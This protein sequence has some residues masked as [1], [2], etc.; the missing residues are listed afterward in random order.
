MH[1]LMFTQEGS[2]GE[3]SGG[4]GKG[5]AWRGWEEEGCLQVQNNSRD[6]LVHQPCQISRDAL[7]HQPC[8]ISRTVVIYFTCNHE[9]LSPSFSCLYVR[10][11][12]IVV[13]DSVFICSGGDKDFVGRVKVFH[14]NLTD[15]RVYADIVWLYRPKE[16]R[17]KVNRK[18]THLVSESAEN[19]VFFSDD[20]GTIEVPT[21][22]RKAHIVTT[23]HNKLPPKILGD[24]SL[25]AKFSF[26]SKTKRLSPLLSERLGSPSGKV[27][28]CVGAVGQTSPSTGYY[29]DSSHGAGT[30]SKATTPHSLGQRQRHCSD[31]R[32]SRDAISDGGLA[33][34]RSPRPKIPDSH[35]LMSS[36]LSV[37]SLLPTKGPRPQYTP[38]RGEPA[39]PENW[40]P[41]PI[42]SDAVVGG[43]RVAASAGRN[44]PRT[45]ECTG[46]GDPKSNSRPTRN[47]GKTIPSKGPSLGEK[48]RERLTVASLSSPRDKQRM[49]NLSTDELL[50]RL[51]GSDTE[52]EE[53]EEEEEKEEEEEEKEEEEEE[54]EEKE[55]G[56]EVIL[57]SKIKKRPTRSSVGTGTRSKTDDKVT[58]IDKQRSKSSVQHDHTNQR[59]ARLGGRESCCTSHDTSKQVKKDC[60]TQNSF[61]VSRK[62]TLRKCKSSDKHHQ[63]FSP[64]EQSSEH[65]DFAAPTPKRR[66]ATRDHTSREAPPRTAS[67]CDA[68][69]EA[70]TP[71]RKKKTSGRTPKPTPPSDSN[72][73]FEAPARKRPVKRTPKAGA[74]TTPTKSRGS[75]PCS[76][77]T[78]V[79]S[80]RGRSRVGTPLGKAVTP[81]IP[82]RSKVRSGGAARGGKK[83]PY[84]LAREK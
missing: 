74:K 44:H 11:Q 36:P 40:S 18:D 34:H 23:R 67:E 9:F 65:S 58:R 72:S 17:S 25:V 57:A 47:K 8:N 6:S 43:K 7:V 46:G 19:E 37:V 5:R 62:R 54:D 1:N 50:H 84:E 61:S 16:L 33:M 78:P 73:N 28:K 69:F 52:E 14:Q 76:L 45:A 64:S 75:R 42:V 81:H 70:P 13:G 60:E 27:H 41:C 29:S 59:S 12:K 66:T 10:L 4:K 80:V 15:Q 49:H 53:E 39:K 55:E 3:E 32:C 35:S 30:S 24:N 51:S 21:I 68:D 77:V 56:E 83:D 79:R 63:N 26:S 71:K 2:E 38:S 82:L 48:R 31:D 22:R 20:N